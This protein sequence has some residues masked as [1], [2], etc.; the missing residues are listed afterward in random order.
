MEYANL[1]LIPFMAFM[2][3]CAGASWCPKWLPAELIFALP[4]AFVAYTYDSPFHFAVMALVWSY[5]GMQLG[6]G[7]FYNMRGVAVDNDQPEKLE[8]LVR[9][10]YTA[11]GGN[12]HKPLYSWACMGFK[13]FFLA[14]PLGFLP[15]LALAILWPFAYF[16]GFRLF[17]DSAEAEVLSGA[18]AGGVICL[19]I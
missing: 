13:G 11:F 3:R 8:E 7:N 2:A 18:F 5:I 1:L 19:L 15:A 14:L 9:P 6:H 17:D 10:I 4:F 12:I 16:W